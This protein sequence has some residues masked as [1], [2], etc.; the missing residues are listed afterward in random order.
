MSVTFFLFFHFGPF[1][2]GRV[3][4]WCGTTEKKKNGQVFELEFGKE[5]EKTREEGN[6]LMA[7]LKQESG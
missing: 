3:V 5:D 4:V 6:I 1:I 7:H 2:F